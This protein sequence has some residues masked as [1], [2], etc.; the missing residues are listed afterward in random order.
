MGGA[1]FIGFPMILGRHRERRKGG[2]EEE[3]RKGG[4]EEERR[5][6]GKDK[7]GWSTKRTPG[8]LCNQNCNQKTDL[9]MGGAYFIGFPV[10]LGRHRERRKGG[11]KEEGRKRR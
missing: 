2:N 6:G 1:Y 3:R 9:F 4:K 11:G 5:K 10:I 7:R 8:A